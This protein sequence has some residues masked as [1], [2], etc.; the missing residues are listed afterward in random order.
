ML[1]TI[2]PAGQQ[3]INSIND[4]QSRLAVSQQQISSGSKVS[5]PSDE[6][7]QISPI[8]QL[9]SAIQQNTDIQNGLNTVMTSL[10]ASDDALSSAINLLQSA[11][12]AATQGASSTQTADTRATLA[13]TVQTL[14]EQMV[15]ASG[16]TIGGR[17]VFSGN[18]DGAPLAAAEPGGQ[19]ATWFAI[20]LTGF[21]AR[22]ALLVHGAPF[23]DDA[24]ITFRFAAN[25]ANGNG[26]VWIPGE[27]VLGT[28]TP[29]YACLLGMAGNLF[30]ATHIP[31]TAVAIGL[32]S[33]LGS[34]ALLRQIARNLRFDALES[35][36]LTF[37]FC[38]TPSIVK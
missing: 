33:Y 32:L 15:A 20:V 26:L 38:F 16:T 29:L 2:S 25:L 13:Q 3:F 17:Y 22:L 34:C 23:Y 5:Q 8:L 28:S 19:A 18:Q 6:P 11:A 12:V 24:F 35:L 36:L 30:G 27:K 21:V 7:D 14:M 31:Y 1:S 4:I 10:K 9:H 37:L